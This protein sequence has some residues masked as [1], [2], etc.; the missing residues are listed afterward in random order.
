MNLIP[1]PLQQTEENV[2]V[3]NVLPF[4]LCIVFS[5]RMIQET[6]ILTFITWHSGKNPL[7]ISCSQKNSDLPSRLHSDA[8]RKV[9]Q[10]LSGKMINKVRT[11][12]R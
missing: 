1:V 6:F 8:K 2:L 9:K 11:A 7:V 12:M 3:L 5:I 4:A 10:L